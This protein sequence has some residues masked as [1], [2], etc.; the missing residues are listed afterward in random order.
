MIIR[1]LIKIL[2]NMCHLSI[3]TEILAF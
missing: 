3:K 1:R 2:G